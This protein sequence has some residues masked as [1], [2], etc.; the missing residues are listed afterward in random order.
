MATNVNHKSAPRKRSKRER[1]N[2]IIV[3]IMIIAMLLS[4]LT[5]GLAFL[6]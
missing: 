5:A 4:T 1:R 2:K 3:Y 6:I